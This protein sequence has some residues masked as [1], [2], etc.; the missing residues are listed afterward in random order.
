MIKRD[1][2]VQPLIQSRRFCRSLS[3]RPHAWHEPRRAYILVFVSQRGVEINDLNVDGS[4]SGKH[5]SFAVPRSPTNHKLLSSTTAN[6]SGPSHNYLHHLS[7]SLSQHE[8][9]CTKCLPL[10]IP[11]T[12]SC[13]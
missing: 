8:H 7:T 10:T 3:H 1:M 12:K 13:I 11:Q 4:R 6:L 5:I 2:R 9:P